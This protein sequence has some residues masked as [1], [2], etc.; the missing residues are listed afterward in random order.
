MRVIRI[1]RESPRI[2]RRCSSDRCY[3][4]PENRRKNIRLCLS[5]LSH[6]DILPSGSNRRQWEAIMAMGRKTTTVITKRE[7][8]RC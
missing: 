1:Q 8:T 3:F 2:A 4:L 6:H 7:A 5:I